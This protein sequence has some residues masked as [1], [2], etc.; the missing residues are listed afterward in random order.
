MGSLKCGMPEYI[1]SCGFECYPDLE[2][3]GYH[4]GVWCK[5]VVG[6]K[7]FGM[8]TIAEYDSIHT[9]DVMY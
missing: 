9:F 3:C 1:L 5:I 6:K 2:F 4:F 7:R 8:V